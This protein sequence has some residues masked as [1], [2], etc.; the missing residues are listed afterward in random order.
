[1]PAGSGD[2][3]FAGAADG[4]VKSAREAGDAAEPAAGA[5]G[6]VESKGA[7]VGVAENPA[8]SEGVRVGAA[9]EGCAE[10]EPPTVDASACAPERR[11]LS[12]SSAAPNWRA[13]P[14]SPV[15]YGWFAAPVS[16]AARGWGAALRSPMSRGWRT[17]PSSS[18]SPGWGAAASPVAWGWRAALRSPVAR[19]WCT[20]LGSVA[21]RGRRAALSS[22]VLSGS[23][24]VSCRAAH[25]GPVPRGVRCRTGSSWVGWSSGSWP[26]SGGGA[27]VRAWR[28]VRSPG[29]GAV[30]VSGG[31]AE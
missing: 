19:G 11:A 17:A 24:F 2:T 16:P 5:E 13:L 31:G 26:G 10:K 3:K 29:M 9:A 18:V 15:A 27:S 30:G 12:E 7:R 20:A 8:E 22:S 4:R 1:M 25:A 28:P 23:L 21:A 14:G 6:A